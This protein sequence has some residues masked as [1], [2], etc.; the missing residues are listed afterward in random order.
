MRAT[1]VDLDGV[2]NN[3]AISWA[4]APGDGAFNVWGNALP[5]EYLPEGGSTVVVE[6]V[7]FR[8]PDKADRRRNDVRCAGQLLAGPGG[9]AEWLYLLTAGERRVEDEIAVHFTDGSVD[10]EAVRVSD[11]WAAPAVFG[12]VAAFTT[13]VMHYPHHVQ[14]GVPATIW[15]QRVPVVRRGAVDFAHLPANAALHIFAATWVTR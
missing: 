2:Y 13:P 14:Q 11:F 12:E 4:H 5:A 10:F 1:T 7:P 3:D 9:P 15:C 8:F 6:D